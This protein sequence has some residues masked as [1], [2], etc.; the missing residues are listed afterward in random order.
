M[1]YARIA[2]T[3]PKDVLA[4][5]DQRA[6][7]SGRARSRVIV[8]AINAFLTAVVSEPRPAYGGDVIGAARL[9]QLERDLAK[10][11]AE[12]LRAAEAASRLARRTRRSASPRQQILGFDSYEDFYEWKKANRA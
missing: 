2:I 10:S 7:Q 12:R 3:L 9:D 6:R 8:E 11:P 5:L 4:R 1:P